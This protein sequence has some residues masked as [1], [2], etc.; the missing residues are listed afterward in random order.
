MCLSRLRF[1][2]IRDRVSYK[3]TKQDAKPINE[4]VKRYGVSKKRTV[5]IGDTVADIRMA[6]RAGV[7]SV[8]VKSGI[9]GKEDPQKLEN[10][11]PDYFLSDFRDLPGVVLRR[12]KS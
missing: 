1:K 2:D 9:L 8:A 4:L 10:E 3:R 5:Y 6:K 12:E 7:I 11:R